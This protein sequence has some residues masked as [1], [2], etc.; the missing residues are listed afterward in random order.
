MTVT[1]VAN[2]EVAAY[3]PSDAL[4]AVTM[5][6]PARELVSESPVIVQFAVPAEVTTY[7]TA[8][9]PEPPLDVSVSG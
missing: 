8:P 9:A 2:D 4:V 1:V 5:H 6:V 3:V 7:D